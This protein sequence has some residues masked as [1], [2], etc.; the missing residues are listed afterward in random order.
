MGAF[1]DSESIFSDEHLKGEKEAEKRRLVVAE[2]LYIRR[3]QGRSKA[4]QIAALAALLK[5][6]DTPLSGHTV[7]NG[8]EFGL[9]MTPVYEKP[10]TLE[11]AKRKA[12]EF[13]AASLAHLDRLVE[14][15]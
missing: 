4:E 8:I 7:L 6:I 5:A 14:G 13:N 11:E 9:D 1:E 3:F 12:A 10:E 15:E 2:R